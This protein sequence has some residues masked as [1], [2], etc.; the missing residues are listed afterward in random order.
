MNGEGAMTFYDYKVAPAP[1]QVKRTRGGST[2]EAFSATLAEAINA[3]A[4]EGW[5]YIRAETLPAE[6]PRGW[7]RRSAEVIETVLIFRRP[8]ESLGPRLAAA[9]VEPE[10][11]GPRLG[12]VERPVERVA[13]RHAERPTER[14]TRPAMPAPLRREPRLGEAVEGATQVRPGGPRLGPADQF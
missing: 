1:R 14:A 9:R 6:E 11:D 7:F 2:A 8:R 12:A 3:A 13:D 4:R 5:E 10:A